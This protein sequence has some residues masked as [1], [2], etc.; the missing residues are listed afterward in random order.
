MCM[1]EFLAGWIILQLVVIGVA[2]A[3]ITNEMTEGIYECNSTTHIPLWLGAVFP[4]A[5]FADD[6][7]SE[8]C[9]E[10]NQ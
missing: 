6:I 8:Y 3:D 9:A 5:V 10:Q 2:T 4:L 7:T 1:R